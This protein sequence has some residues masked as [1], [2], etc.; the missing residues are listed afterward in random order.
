MLLAYLAGSGSYCGLL[1]SHK[2]F[3][4][5]LA[6]MS[7]ENQYQYSFLSLSFPYSLSLFSVSF[8]FTFYLHSD[9]IQ[10]MSVYA[11]ANFLRG[12]ELGAELQE[13]WL[14]VNAAVYLWNYNN[15]ILATK[16]Q[17]KLVPTFNQLVELLKQTGHAG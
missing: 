17:H 6:G 12:A 7:F 16:G 1:T 15:H 8:F 3:T 5:L 9:W 2:I 13:P 10:E 11:T 4:T 14:V